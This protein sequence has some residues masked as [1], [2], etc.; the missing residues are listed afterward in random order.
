MINGLVSL[1]FLVYDK[2][3]L[4]DT[5]RLPLPTMLGQAQKEAIQLL[6]S[7]GAE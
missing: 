2:A 5:E 7:D 4:H 6:Q 1:L 3:S